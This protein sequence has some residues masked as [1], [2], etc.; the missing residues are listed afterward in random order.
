[1]PAGRCSNN[2]F[3]FLSLFACSQEGAD[4]YLP[5]FSSWR[6]WL[7]KTMWRPKDGVVSSLLLQPETSILAGRWQLLFLLTIPLC[8]PF[9]WLISRRLSLSLSLQVTNDPLCAFLKTSRYCLF[10][11]V[12][13]ENVSFWTSFSRPLTASLTWDN[14][15]WKSTNRK[16]MISSFPSKWTCLF[17]D[18]DKNSTMDRRGSYFVTAWLCRGLAH[19]AII[20]LTDIPCRIT[21]PKK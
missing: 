19:P 13:I 16:L 3:E 5:K 1:M 2:G 21:I 14:V 4:E 20:A 6:G 17:N 7:G 15:H 10:W 18:H 11:I 12:T 8:L 9:P